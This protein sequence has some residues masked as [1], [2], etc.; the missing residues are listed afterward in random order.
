MFGLVLYVSGLE[1]YFYE[2]FLFILINKNYF[3]KKKLKL[4]YFEI[5]YWS[6]LEFYFY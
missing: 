4:Y 3:G 5:Y 1:F 6:M 2:L